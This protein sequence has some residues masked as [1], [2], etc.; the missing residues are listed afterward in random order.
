MKHSFFPPA[1]KRSSSWKIIILLITFLHLSSWKWCGVCWHREAELFLL[2]FYNCFVSS[3]IYSCLYSFNF[4][5]YNY[6]Q[7]QAVQFLVVICAC[8]DHFHVHTSTTDAI[9]NISMCIPIK[10]TLSQ[11]V[12][13]FVA[14]ES[15]YYFQSFSP[16]DKF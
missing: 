7:I 4:A 9:S 13:I 11:N 3:Y 6:A 16:I 5:S 14:H 15:A 8:E 10:T 2:Y 12:V 1:N